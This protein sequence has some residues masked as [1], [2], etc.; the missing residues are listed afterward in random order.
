MG[1]A[2]HILLL[3]VNLTREPVVRTPTEERNPEE[4]EAH[5]EQFPARVDDMKMDNGKMRLCRWDTWLSGDGASEGDGNID[6]GGNIDGRRRRRRA[7]VR[8]LRLTCS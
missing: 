1:S 2:T 7:P 8:R 5:G 3:A 6:G 4:E